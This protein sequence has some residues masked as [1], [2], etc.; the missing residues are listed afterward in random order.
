MFTAKVIDVANQINV[1][2]PVAVKPVP[3][4][5]IKA[6]VDTNNRPV[7]RKKKMAKK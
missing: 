4:H 5:N 1:A 7:K 3:K 2:R 6:K